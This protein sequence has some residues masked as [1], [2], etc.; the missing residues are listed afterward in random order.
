M[1]GPLNGK[2]QFVI[3][4]VTIVVSVLA[5]YFT[6]QNSTNQR[7]TVVETQGS[8]RWNYVKSSLERIERNQDADRS[9]IRRIVQDWRDGVNRRTGEP[10]PLQRSLEP[11]P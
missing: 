3:G 4:I 7:I 8:E 10:L 6:T 5:S 1:A 11:G 9:E 2:T